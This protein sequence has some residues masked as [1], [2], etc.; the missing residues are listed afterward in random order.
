MVATVASIVTSEPPLVDTFSILFDDIFTQT[1][2]FTIESGDDE[3][4]DIGNLRPKDSF[5]TAQLNGDGS[6]VEITVDGP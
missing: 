6:G 4:I 5:L 3:D 2:L 1:F